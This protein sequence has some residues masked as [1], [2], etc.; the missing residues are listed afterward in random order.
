[1]GFPLWVKEWMD[2]H[3]LT[4]HLKPLHDVGFGD[5]EFTP[6]LLEDRRDDKVEAEL[7]Q[8]LNRIRQ[9]DTE[10]A[11]MP[12]PPGSLDISNDGPAPNRK[13]GRIVL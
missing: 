5:A 3:S 4:R 6:G 2:S 7:E 11:G 10:A 9:R 1:M 8:P 12:V 13:P